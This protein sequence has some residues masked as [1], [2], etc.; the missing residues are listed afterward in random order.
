MV[1]GMQVLINEYTNRHFGFCQNLPCAFI[2]RRIVKQTLATGDLTNQ[3]IRIDN[4][5]CKTKNFAQQA[6]SKIDCPILISSRS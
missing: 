4:A 5:R 3:P 1:D 2:K 6:P